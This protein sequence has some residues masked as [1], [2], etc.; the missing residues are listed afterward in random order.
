MQAPLVVVRL[1]FDKYLANPCYI[2]CIVNGAAHIF[3]Q[4][5]LIEQTHS[6]CF[7]SVSNSTLLET[8]TVSGS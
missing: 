2:Y 1:I 6:L 3:L 4:F 7:L 8:R 5:A